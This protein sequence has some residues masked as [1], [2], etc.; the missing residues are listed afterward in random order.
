[1]VAF[2]D[3]TGPC[4]KPCKLGVVDGKLRRPHGACRIGPCSTSCDPKFARI[5]GALGFLWFATIDGSSALGTA[6]LGPLSVGLTGN[7]VSC[8]IRATTC[9]ESVPK[10]LSPRPL[11]PDSPAGG[12]P[13]AHPRAVG[14]Q[15]PCRPS[16]RQRRTRRGRPVRASVSAESPAI[17]RLLGLFGFSTYLDPSGA[18][19]SQ[20]AAAHWH[21]G[22]Q[23]FV[24]HWPLTSFRAGPCGRGNLCRRRPRERRAG[25]GSGDGPSATPRAF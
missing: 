15:P 9:R 1:M 18:A 20:E 8:R 10:D 12:R 23:R 6:L 21:G 25:R 19:Q 5:S 14:S 11:V 13:D 7:P 24:N 3:K 22:Q 17:L 16:C 4:G 2:H